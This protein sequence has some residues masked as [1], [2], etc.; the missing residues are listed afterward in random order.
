MSET[1]SKPKTYLNI[2]VATFQEVGAKWGEKNTG[3]MAA[4]IA[5]YSMMSL[6][7]LL[8]FIIGMVGLFF[9]E[10]LVE[11]QLLTGIAEALG[12]ET[13]EFV[14]GVIQGAFEIDRSGPILAIIGLV[15][16]IFFASTVFNSVKLALNHIWDVTPDVAPRSGIVAFLWDRLLA[17]AMVLLTG[18]A[19]FVVMISSVLSAI[20]SGWLADQHWQQAGKIATLSGQWVGVFVLLGLI[21][22]AYKLLPDTAV[23]WRYALSGGA[24]ATVLFIVGN[25]VMGIYFSLSSLPTVYGAAGSLVVLL[26]WVY[27]SSY[28]LL[29]GALFTR[30]LT[31]QM[32]GEA[33]S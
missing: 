11:E 7:P 26:L 24:L 28:I 31:R 6:A 17:S 29:F 13:A 5:F 23:L 30:A 12:A 2:L 19:L 32:V 21:T 16:I 14:A 10:S 8:A 22:I 1:T 27:Y 33:D 9:S 15:I 3:L 4:A 18:G 25:K 20:V